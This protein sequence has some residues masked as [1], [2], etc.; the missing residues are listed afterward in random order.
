MFRK[1][2]IVTA[3]DRAVDRA[4]RPLLETLAR[5]GVPPSAERVYKGSRNSIYTLEIPSLGTVSIKEFKIPPFPNN[6]V[7]CGLRGSKA[8]RSFEHAMILTDSGIQTPRPFGYVEV[9]AGVPVHLGRSYYVC[10]HVPYLPI[11][12]WEADPEKAPRVAREIGRFTAQMHKAGIYHRD[13]SRGNLLLV[14]DSEGEPCGISL[15][16]LNRMNFHVRDSALLMRMFAGLA[17]TEDAMRHIVEAY[18]KEF[19]V[20]PARVL[21]RVLDLQQ[22]FIR[23]FKRKNHIK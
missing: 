17:W 3:P 14:T 13:F 11:R 18:S 2:I 9:R 10:Q 1:K 19:G 6:F 21:P 5:E 22:K 23:A 4:I 12:E 16:D 7:Y 8:R 20:D 15:L